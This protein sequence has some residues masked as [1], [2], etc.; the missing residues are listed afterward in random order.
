MITNKKYILFDL[1]GTL[2][3]PKVGIC[4]CVQY[5]LKEFGIEEPDLDKLEPFIGP[6][7]KDSF[8][9][10]Y[11]LT[12]EQAVQAIA[13]YRERFS[14]VGKFENEIYPGISDLLVDLKN[15]GY[16]LAVASSKPEVYV[17]EILEHFH[18][19]QYFDAIVGAELDGARTDKA[20]VIYEA[21]NRL[22][23]YGRIYK[24]Q[25]VMV[26]DR[27]FDVQGAKEMEVTSVAV[28]YGYGPKEELE[29]A[30]PDYI[31]NTVKELRSVFVDDEEL[32]NRIEKN[33]QEQLEKQKAAEEAKEKR[34]KGNPINM[35]WQFLFP[36]LLF[37]F[38]GEFLRQ[39]F[40]YVL[41]LLAEKIPVL[42]NFMFIAADSDETRLA[43][44]GNGNGLIQVFALLGVTVVLYKLGGG[45]QCLE[46]VK[47]K[48]GK[49]AP[50]EWGIWLAI[51]LLAAVGLNMTFAALGFMEVSSYEEVASNLYAVGI[52]MGILLYGVCS[53]IAEELLF[54]GIIFSEVKGFMKPFGASL[55][56]S[57]LFGIYHGN[58]VQ[59]VYSVFLGIILAFAYHYS[60]Q[61]LVPIVIHGI[62]N[63][64][65]FLASNL[66][67]L[68]G[69]TV[70]LVIGII[71]AVLSFVLFKAQRKKYERK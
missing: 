28:S 21:L 32:R 50:S 1:D 57:A 17:K 44:S 12:E 54:R 41:M 8:M 39:A 7:L 62:V 6:P 47:A 2:T 29:Q 31:V 13:K 19:A 48:A 69:G 22:F 58:G 45:K 34:K 24:D 20:E 52:P 64:C 35:V 4:T 66:G 56:S 11:G 10:F 59:L 33:R 71:C 70:Q 5:A 16:R 25:I 51:A 63:I 15:Y 40:A 65:V 37:Y 26:G 68:T 14:T 46:A 49:F 60:N 9:E 43:I 27:K 23:H 18:I 67:L 36:F 38:A 30:A 55:L 61:L 53:P 42:F 3:D